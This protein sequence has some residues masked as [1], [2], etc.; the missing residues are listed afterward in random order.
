MGL[1]GSEWECDGGGDGMTADAVFSIAN[2]IALLSWI[3]LAAFPKSGVTK[4]VTGTV[5]PGLLAA[6]Y[7]GIV[8][9]VF[10]R[11]EGG[12]SSLAEVAALFGNKWMLLAGWIHYLAFDLLIGGWITADSGK[13]GVPRWVVVPCL[14]LTFLFGPAGW[15]L[16]RVV[17][18]ASA[19]V[20]R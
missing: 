4:L 10:G 20:S 12:F 19:K 5:V 18:A 6:V 17:R 7:V 1:G 8:A 16:Y 11:V 3:W 2:T 15:L 14:G 9:T 13:R